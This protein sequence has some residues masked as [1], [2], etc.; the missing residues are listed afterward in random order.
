MATLKP[1]AEYNRRAAITEDLCAERLAT[2]I[3]TVQQRFQYASEK[4]SESFDSK[5]ALRQRQ[6]VLFTCPMPWSFLTKSEKHCA[7]WLNDNDHG[8]QW[9]Y[10]MIPY[11]NDNRALV[12]DKGFSDKERVAL[13]ATSVTKHERK[14][15][16][17]EEEQEEEEEKK[18]KD[19]AT[20]R[21]C[22]NSIIDRMIVFKI[23]CKRWKAERRCKPASITWKDDLH[24]Y[25]S[26]QD[27]VLSNRGYKYKHWDDPNE[28]VDCL[29]L[30]NASHRADNNA[31]DN[32]ILSI[33]E[34]LRETGLIID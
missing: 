28:L 8:M 24:K 34:E 26:S 4:E 5:L 2:E 31:H 32:E 23:G 20:P 13:Q 1:S 7:S 9:K 10:G 21:F 25:K 30:L 22:V 16:E 15:E 29:R 17:E 14:K 27:R 6:Y 12:Y 18:E 33:I 11:E 3:R 19:S